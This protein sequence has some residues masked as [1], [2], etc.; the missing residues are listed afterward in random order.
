VKGS[1]TRQQRVSLPFID[2]APVVSVLNSVG[3]ACSAPNR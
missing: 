3:Q 2:A 1:P